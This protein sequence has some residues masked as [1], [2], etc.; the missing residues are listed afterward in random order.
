[1]ETSSVSGILK[2]ALHSALSRQSSSPSPEIPADGKR[3]DAVKSVI[4]QIISNKRLLNNRL[5]KQHIISV[6]LQT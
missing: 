5:K 1:M 2:E 6:P 3:N 4:E